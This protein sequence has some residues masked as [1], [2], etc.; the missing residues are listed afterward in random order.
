MH[1]MGQVG[2]GVEIGG[3]IRRLSDGFNQGGG[4]I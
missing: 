2:G 3:E 4:F 1:V